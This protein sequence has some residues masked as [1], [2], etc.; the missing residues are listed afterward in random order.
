MNTIPSI[1]GTWRGPVYFGD[2][3][4]SCVLT[5]VIRQN[6]AGKL[7]GMVSSRPPPAQFSMPVR[8]EISKELECLVQSEDDGRT[9]IFSGALANNCLTGTVNLGDG[10]GIG[11]RKGGEVRLYKALPVD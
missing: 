7:S 8:G 11:P 1:E 2:T 10:T 9:L 4:T 5:L 3:P 6:D